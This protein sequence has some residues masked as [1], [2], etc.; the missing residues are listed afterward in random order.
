MSLKKT[1]LALVTFVAVL[2]SSKAYCQIYTHAATPF[3]PGYFGHDLQ[4]FAPGDFSEFGGNQPEMPIG[5]YFNYSRLWL[6]VSRPNV[7][8]NDF[9]TD[10]GWGN[11]YQVGY[12]T[13]DDMGW[14]LEVVRMTGPQQFNTQTFSGAP[15]AGFNA[16][17]QPVN[18]I[19]YNSVELNRVY[20]MVSHGGSVFEPFIGVR[21]S[22]LRDGSDPVNFQVVIPPNDHQTLWTGITQ[23][24]MIGGQIGFRWF[25]RKGRWTLSGG[26]KAYPAINFQEY[27]TQDFAKNEFTLGSDARFEASYNITRDIS[28]VVGFEAIYYGMGIAR[29]SSFASEDFLMVGSTFGL[30]V[31]YR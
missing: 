20:R 26:L 4:F 15:S 6:H 10:S 28:L 7:A 13:Q 24:N 16:L 3:E 8:F 25:K 12:M 2:A 23:N 19:R 29:A 30:E 31:N 9:Q 21:Y 14:D 11:R 1:F 17:I 5:W 22:T 18:I 27:R